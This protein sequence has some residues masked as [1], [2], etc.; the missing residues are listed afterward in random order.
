MRKERNKKRKPRTQQ[1]NLPAKRRKT[2]EETFSVTFS[3]WETECDRQELDGDRNVTEKRKEQ[4]KTPKPKRL[5]LTQDDIRKFLTPN[6][7]ELLLQ[8]A[9]ETTSPSPQMQQLATTSI[10]LV[11]VDQLQQLPSLQALVPQTQD[12]IIELLP[13][14]AI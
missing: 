8:P 11:R 13:Q 1:A 3:S 2:G 5:K 9:I 4:L 14:L 10:A 12:D 6:I 7:I